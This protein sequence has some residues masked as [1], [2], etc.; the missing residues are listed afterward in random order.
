MRILG[1]FLIIFGLLVIGIAGY[2][3]WDNKVSADKA[4]AEAHFILNQQSSVS[5]LSKNKDEAKQFTADKNEIVGKVE[6]PKLEREIA[7]VEG[8]NEDALK[9]G[10]GHVTS[11]GFPAQG[12]QIVLSGHRDTVFR[13]FGQLEIGDRFI[14]HMPYGVFEYE[15]KE[16]EIVPEDDTS[17]IGR[18]SE[19]VLVVS[20][21]Y[22]FHFVGPAPDRYVTY[23]YP[24]DEG[25]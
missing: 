4:L 9:Q 5:D 21:C 23:A 8:A 10:V 24:V 14:V 6:I 18:H 11:T 3:I 16:E 25:S 22:P 13:D 1:K 7:I 12:K 19:E 20:T 17:V 2:Q 15:I